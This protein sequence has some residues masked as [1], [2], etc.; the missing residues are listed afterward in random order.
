MVDNQTYELYGYVVASGVF[1]EAY[2]LPLESSFKNVKDQL[3]AQDV[4]LP[5]ASEV[6]SW[7]LRASHKSSES[8]SSGFQDS[9]LVRPFRW[10]NHPPSLEST[11]GGYLSRRHEKSSIPFESPQQFDSINAV[12][13]L[14]TSAG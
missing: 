8:N 12:P 2:V 9:Q 7:L 14:K 5:E 3:R 11:D 6:A 1:G 10:S 13:G 4:C